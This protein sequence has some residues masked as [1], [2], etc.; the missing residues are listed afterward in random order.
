MNILRRLRRTAIGLVSTAAVVLAT[1][2]L[3]RAFDARHMGPLKPW[4][5]VAPA[6][7]VTARDLDDAFSIRQYLAREETVFEEVRTR[8]E[9]AIAP[10]DREPA[11]R[12]WPDGPLSPSR[13][14]KDWN[15]TFELVPERIRGG[16]LLV[17]GLTD[18]P[19]SMRRLA[20]IYRDLGFYALALRMPG[21]GTV[22]GAL[23][24]TDWTDWAAAV[25]VGARHVTARAGEGAPF[26]IVGYS[27][28]GAL[29]VDYALD[30][31]DGAKLPKA[32]RLVLVSPMIGVGRAAGFARVFGL[33]GVF[34]YFETS[35]WLDVM[36]EYIPFKYVSFPV[37]AATQ[38]AAL[39]KAI[40]AKTTRAVKTR[41]I[42]GLPPI[43]TFVSL[44]DATVRTDSTVRDL[45]DRLGSN[46]SE[47][48]V[49]DV[50]RSSVVRPFLRR[51]EEGR[52]DRLLPRRLRPYRLTVVTNAAAGTREVV[53]RN[54]AAGREDAGVRPLGLSW[55]DGVY[56]LSHVALPFPPD[57]PLYG[58]EPALDDPFPVQLGTLQPRGE[59]AVLTVPVEQL[60]RLT[61]NPFFSLLE[62]RVRAWA[63]LPVQ[64]AEPR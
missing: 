59:R 1:I 33:L 35:R 18:A 7:E 14:P 13:L 51:R 52:L 26:H 58:N 60:M 55:P 21:H 43:L 36:P 31:L 42:G 19:Y 11:N 23:T 62:E 61:W 22:P 50:N 57:D 9:S 49:F 63:S 12:Y 24:R 41:T 29:A 47:L 53:E 48:V 56:S 38:T 40:R 20:E 54:V 3:V 15:R 30:V 45:Y 4:Q 5:K 44:V 28:G 17:H 37:N 8:V 25:R 64:P 46:G 34:P 16:V 10:G 2:V 32:D 6:S 39:T 27:N